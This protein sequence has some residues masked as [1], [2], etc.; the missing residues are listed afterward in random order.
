MVLFLIIIADLTFVGAI[1]ISAA[2]GDMG[3]ALTLFVAF[4]LWQIP[5][6]LILQKEYCE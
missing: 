5:A 6:K 4:S 2:S 1:L 3:A